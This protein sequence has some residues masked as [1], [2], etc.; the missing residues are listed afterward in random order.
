MQQWEEKILEQKE[1]Q[2]IGREIGRQE[3]RKKLN[4]LITKLSSIGRTDDIIKAA[5]D[6]EFQQQLLEEFHL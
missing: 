5:S 3:E 2:E 1:N 4:L 6:P